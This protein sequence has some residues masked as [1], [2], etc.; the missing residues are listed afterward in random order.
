MISNKVI[1][2]LV[3]ISDIA[4]TSIY[5]VIVSIIFLFIFNKL[6][7]KLLKKINKS[8]L[9]ELLIH[10]CL[11]A[12][13][14]CIVA[15]L[16]KYGAEEIPNPITLLISNYSKKTR[17]VLMFNVAYIIIPIVLLTSSDFSKRILEILRRLNKL[18]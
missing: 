16:L 11:Q 12:S 18:F 13:V 5:Y 4:V 17:S 6:S 8:S 9:S 1:K 14:I 10:V 3:E 15:H 2:N 7:N